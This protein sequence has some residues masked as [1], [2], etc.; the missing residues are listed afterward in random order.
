MDDSEIKRIIKLLDEGVEKENAKVLL[1]QYGGGPEESQIVANKEG[2]LRFGIE[3]MKGAYIEKEETHG[4]IPVDLDFEYLLSSDSDVFFDLC[5]RRDIVDQPHEPESLKDKFMSGLALLVVF[6]VLGI[7]GAGFI[8]GI[9][10]LF[11]FF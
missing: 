11:S 1:G 5:E 2:F 7:M 4:K 3:I 9:R 10:W 8:N 6:L